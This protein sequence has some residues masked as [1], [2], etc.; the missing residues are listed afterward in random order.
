M[1][2]FLLFASVQPGLEQQARTELQSE[3]IGV[4]A[5]Y[6]GGFEFY[7]HN[8]AVYRLNNRLKTVSR[9]LIRFASFYTDSF[10]MLENR[11][12]KLPWEIY[13]KDQYPVIRVNTRSSKLYH[14]DAVKERLLSS[15]FFRL[16][17]EM[18]PLQNK[19]QLIVVNIEDDIMN[20]SID[21]SGQ[22]LHK[23]GWAPWKTRAPLRETIASAIVL[24]CPA[25]NGAKRIAD[26]MCGSGTLLFETASILMRMPLFPFRSFSFESFPS[27]QEEIYGRVK[28]VLQEEVRPLDAELSGY[29][30]DEQ[31]I[32]ACHH[33][34]A[35]MG[36]GGNFLLQKRDCATI[37]QKELQGCA[38][39]SNPPYGIR[40]KGH[41]APEALDLL[42]SLRKKGAVP[43][44]CLLLDP[45]APLSKNRFSIKFRVK[46]GNI[47]V[48]C[49]S[50]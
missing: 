10:W 30:I 32:R 14:K 33:N 37:T 35:A 43:C 49:I 24:S 18:D 40:L 13:F 15:I 34:I 44:L 50:F 45:S 29:D 42:Y 16:G 48:Y 22:H 1:K 6:P 5:E 21:T 11:A 20:I 46:N 8:N 25:I 23:R 26:P 27:F 2:P 7:G 17:K 31:S 9:I 19:E 38:I 47:P 12:K 4:L 36:I 3:G 41:T 28:T 39:I